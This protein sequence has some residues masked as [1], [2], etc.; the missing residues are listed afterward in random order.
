MTTFVDTNVMGDFMLIVLGTLV[1]GI[2]INF[3]LFV[4][5]RGSPT[6]RR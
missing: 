6:P 1:L 5:F 4:L 3:A 2:V